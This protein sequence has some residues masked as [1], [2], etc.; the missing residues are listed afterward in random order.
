M[1]GRAK[2][3]VGDEWEVVDPPARFGDRGITDFHRHKEGLAWAYRSKWDH[4]TS[5]RVGRHT[6]V[7]DSQEYKDVSHHSVFYGTYE[8]SWKLRSE[9]IRYAA[10]TVAQQRASRTLATRE[11]QGLARELLKLY[12]VTQEKNNKLG[13]RDYF[14]SRFYKDL[15]DL[16]PSVARGLDLGGNMFNP[17]RV[18]AAICP[19]PQD[20]DEDFLYFKP[21]GS[22]GYKELIDLGRW[23]MLPKEPVQHPKLPARLEVSCER[24]SVYFDNSINDL[25]VDGFEVVE[26]VPNKAQKE[27]IARVAGGCENIGQRATI[28]KHGRWPVR[29]SLLSDLERQGVK[30]SDLD[31]PDAKTIKPDA[32]RRK[33][34]VF[35]WLDSNNAYGPDPG[36]RE[37]LVTS[38]KS[39]AARDPS[40]WP[41]LDP[42]E[43]AEAMHALGITWA[44][45]KEPELALSSLRFD[46]ARFMREWGLT[47]TSFGPERFMRFERIT[48][49]YNAWRNKVLER[50]NS[51]YEPADISGDPDRLIYALQLLGVKL[52]RGR[53][54]SLGR[55]DG[56]RVGKVGQSRHV[57][58]PKLPRPLP[59]IEDLPGYTPD[60]YARPIETDLAT[61]MRDLANSMGG[62][63]AAKAL[64]RAARNVDA[65]QSIRAA[66]RALSGVNQ[67]L[68]AKLGKIASNLE[69]PA[70]E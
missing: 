35:G 38:Y 20:K 64:R 19:Y 59:R 28:K 47:P 66:Q 26:G 31:A 67:D 50:S 29:P 12:K 14:Q 52:V 21:Y 42:A 13:N 41:A 33:D 57:E 17:K 10:L 45:Y 18:D 32:E 11:G 30:P 39:F 25:W 8:T 51:L 40:K 65:A 62:S 56:F 2:S 34:L 58:T 60:K 1:R 61:K 15:L 24:H 23:L 43:V 37:R 55:V 54:M 44:S 22:K 16:I 27:V 46:A 7:W 70:S 4:G 5:Y 63:E 9:A 3:W 36:S 49:F 68:A 53:G 6:P 69:K 48:E